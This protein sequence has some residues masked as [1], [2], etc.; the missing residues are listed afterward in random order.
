MGIT[1]EEM[2]INEPSSKGSTEHVKSYYVN[3]LKNMKHNVAVLLHN[4]TLNSTDILDIVCTFLLEKYKVPAHYSQIY[5]KKSLPNT[6]TSHNQIS[7]GDHEN[8]TVPKTS[9][10]IVTG[11]EKYAQL[12]QKL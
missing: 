3:A 9:S 7:N 5:L 12:F 8:E 1:S 11:I 2:V 10:V 6:I 4:A